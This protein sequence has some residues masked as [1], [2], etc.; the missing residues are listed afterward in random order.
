MLPKKEDRCFEYRK[1]VD[2]FQ[3][4]VPRDWAWDKGCLKGEGSR[5]YAHMAMTMRMDGLHREAL[6]CD[7]MYL[8]RPQGLKAGPPPPP[9]SWASTRAGALSPP[10]CRGGSRETWLDLDL[11]GSEPNSI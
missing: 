7:G 4:V 10:T 11:S 6:G 9:K 5:G 3:E 1:G 2:P 8:G